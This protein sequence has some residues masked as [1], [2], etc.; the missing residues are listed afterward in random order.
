[1]S[2]RALI[3]GAGGF[4]G[5]Y[6]RA[7]LEDNGWEVI[8][9]SLEPAAGCRPC[10]VTRPDQVEALIREAGSLSHVFHLAA[11]T[12]VP[13]AMREPDTVMQVNY[14]G[15]VNVIKAVAQLAH[16]ARV[17][18]IGSADA[19][20]PP[21]QLPVTEAHPLVPQNPYA[22]AKAAADHYCRFAGK[23]AGV[24]IVRLRPFNHTGPGQADNFVLASFARQVAEI[25][26]GLR[27]PVLRV[28]NLQAARD[29][30]HVKDVV[31]GYE[32]AALHGEA[33]EVYNICSG[34]AQ[35]LDEA[36]RL[37]CDLARVPVKVEVD[38]ARLRPV[39]V[40]TVAGSHEKFTARTG[41]EPEVAFSGLLED[42]LDYWRSQQ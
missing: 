37:L 1:M 9:A 8:C 32:L 42:L 41:W 22:I 11:V 34:K 5:R 20:G 36:V 35:P 26:A 24:D 7:Q 38:A 6:L 19:Y 39:D 33:G 40:K 30:L 16:G 28:G 17:V 13:F 3:T 14:G 15:T 27:D 2:G 29:F 12:F 18:F 31:R 10:D 23:S 4:V 21:Q 25:E